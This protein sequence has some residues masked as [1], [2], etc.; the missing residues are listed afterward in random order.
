MMPNMLQQNFGGPHIIS[1]TIR[2]EI[3]TTIPPLI[4]KYVPIENHI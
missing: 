1:K 3:P 4:A 2:I